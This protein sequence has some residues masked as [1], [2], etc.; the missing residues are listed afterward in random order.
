MLRY[1]VVSCGKASSL[2][3]HP[4]SHASCF[5][6]LRAMPLILNSLPTSIFI[7][8]PESWKFLCGPTHGRLQFEGRD[9]NSMS[10]H[11]QVQQGTWFRRDLQ[12]GSPWTMLLLLPTSSNPGGL[13]FQTKSASALD[14][15]LVEE[16]ILGGALSDKGFGQDW[17]V[18]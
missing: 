8:R 12:H 9:G 13:T 6:Q 10:I 15:H 11:G 17:D 14:P 4:P 5:L 2:R 18:L 16:R 7:R 1:S 3:K